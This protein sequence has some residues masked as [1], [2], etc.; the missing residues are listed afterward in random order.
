MRQSVSVPWCWHDNVPNAVQ[1]PD[2]EYT[3]DTRAW[4]SDLSRHSAINTWNISAT[5]TQA[6]HRS[7]G[8]SRNWWCWSGTRDHTDWMNLTIFPSLNMYSCAFSTLR[9]CL[10]STVHRFY[11]ILLCIPSKWLS[12]KYHGDGYILSWIFIDSKLG[13]LR[14]WSE[15]VRCPP[16]PL[17]MVQPG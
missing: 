3:R 17:V 2:T 5:S 10:V 4:R 16:A 12:L 14:N 15:Y 1:W 8:T 9:L 7:R 6:R 13:H 11:E